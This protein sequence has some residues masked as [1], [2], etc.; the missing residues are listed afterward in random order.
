MMTRPLS[1]A[2]ASAAVGMAIAAAPQPAAPIFTSEQAAAGRVAY[3]ASCA[4]CHLPDLR[5]RNEASPLAGANFI[6]AW[7]GRS[8]RELIGFM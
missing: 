3:Q 5:G 1:L 4:S 7:R 6:N 8:T 2:A